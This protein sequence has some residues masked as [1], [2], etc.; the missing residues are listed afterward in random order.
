MTKNKTVLNDFFFR[1]DLKDS[2]K[3]AHNY[4]WREL[5]KFFSLSGDYQ[6]ALLC[7]HEKCPKNPIPFS[8][9]G[10]VPYLDF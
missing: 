6:S 8:T 2:S 7:D 4:H 10:L 1:N 9:I 5:R 3:K